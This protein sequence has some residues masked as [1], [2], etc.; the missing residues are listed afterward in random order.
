MTTTAAHIIRWAKKHGL[1]I[2]TAES[3][4]G[5]LVAAA[6]TSIPGASQ[7]FK[8]GLLAY[9][10]I[11]KHELLGIAL[12]DITKHGAVSQEI[13]IKMALQG[14]R[15]LNVD[16]CIALTGNAGPTTSSHKPVGCVY[17]AVANHGGI[18]I[19]EWR[20]SGTRTAIRRAAAK[21]ALSLLEEQLRDA[22]HV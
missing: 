21:A 8:G 3:V 18:T 20:F 22:T 5:G 9:T 16:Y 10:D 11:M 6:L 14:A 12:D 7:V 4:T 17:I 2:G 13:A 19:K 1:T 15:R